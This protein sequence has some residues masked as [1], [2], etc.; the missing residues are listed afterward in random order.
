MKYIFALVLGSFAA[1]IIGSIMNLTGAS[2]TI[3]AWMLSFTISGHD[4]GDR[5]N[6]LV[7][8]LLQSSKIDGITG[9]SYLIGH[10]ISEEI[11]K[12]VMFCIVFR[13]F[14]PS[15]I[16]EIILTG[17]SVGI[18]FALCETIAYHNATPFF[19]LQ[20][21]FLRGAGHGLFTGLLAML[22][23]F[24]YFS[25]LRWIDAGAKKN[26]TVWFMRYAELIVLIF[27]TFMG[28]IMAACLH[29][30]MNILTVIGL[31]VLA[32]VMLTVC[33]SIFITVL[34]RPESRRPYGDILREMDLLQTITHARED[35]EEMEK[36]TH[37]IVKNKAQKA[38][39][40]RKQFAKR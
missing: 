2:T 16:R 32:I 38:H 9:F 24:G 11:V 33:W 5:M 7:R 21:I 28:L 19:Q 3:D 34:V 26:M 4:V 8:T 27:W 35:L 1:L 6:M 23:G 39:F 29:S 30:M 31:Q 17:I 37:A 40:S 14:R 15:S 10:S 22:F 12:F 18:G 13:L 25:Q 20:S 36:T